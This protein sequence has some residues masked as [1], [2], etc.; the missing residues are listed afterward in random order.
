M[1]CCCKKNTIDMECQKKAMMNF[2]SI[3]MDYYIKKAKIF[4]TFFK[5]MYNNEKFRQSITFINADVTRIVVIKLQCDSVSKMRSAITFI[6]LEKDIEK[7]KR[8][9]EFLK[10]FGEDDLREEYHKRNMKKIHKYCIEMN[11]EIPP[12]IVPTMIQE[13]PI[14]VENLE[15]DLQ[16]LEEKLAWDALK[17]SYKEKKSKELRTLY[18]VDAELETD[19]E[20]DPNGD[21]EVEPDSISIPDGDAEVEP[22]TI[23]I[24]DGDA[25]VEPDPIS[26][27]NGDAEVE[28]EA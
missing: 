6:E 21:A 20:P 22:N 11:V 28:T 23:S 13:I 16:R 24:P 1:N 14:T 12:S 8:D 19:V 9:I 5:E 27:P 10:L 18:N 3:Y 17:V 26:I 25:E 7:L 4:H 15:K 2:H